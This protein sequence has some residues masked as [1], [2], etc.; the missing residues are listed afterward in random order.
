MK[1]I[2]KNIEKLKDKFGETIDNISSGNSTD[3]KNFPWFI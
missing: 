3:N 1:K 2:D